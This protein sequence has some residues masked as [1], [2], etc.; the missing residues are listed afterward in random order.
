MRMPYRFYY[1]RWYSYWM[2]FSAFRRIL[3]KLR[4]QDE[5]EELIAWAKR[6]RLSGPL[7]SYKIK[8]HHIERDLCTLNIR[9]P[10]LT[11]LARTWHFLRG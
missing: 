6:K 10:Q 9:N 2:A 1:T 5:L 3:S 8:L 11:R 7:K 4:Y